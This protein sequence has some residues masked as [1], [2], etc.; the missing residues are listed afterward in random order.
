MKEQGTDPVSAQFIDVD[1]DFLKTYG[2]ELKE[3]RFFSDDYATDS[4]AVLIN[5]AAEKE[6]RAIDPVGKDLVALANKEHNDVFHIIGVIKDFNYESLHRN[7]QT[8]GTSLPFCPAA[9]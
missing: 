1:K 2:I 8:V 6:F 9:C 4:T 5:E 3:G 7:I